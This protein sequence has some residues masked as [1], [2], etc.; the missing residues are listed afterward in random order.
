MTSLE[1]E[2]ISSYGLN[3]LIKTYIK[4]LNEL[5][6]QTSTLKKE[7]DAIKVAHATYVQTCNST[8]HTIKKLRAAED[9]LFN[10][11]KTLPQ[12]VQ[13]K[14][15]KSRFYKN[16]TE[17][18]VP[19]LNRSKGLTT[20]SYASLTNLFK[21]GSGTPRR[22]GGDPDYDKT[23]FK[24]MLNGSFVGAIVGGLIGFIYGHACGYE[25]TSSVYQDELY[26]LA[27]YI[28]N[29]EHELMGRDR[30]IRIL[31]N[32]VRDIEHAH[33]Q[34][35]KSQETNNEDM[36]ATHS[37]ELRLAED[38]LVDTVNKLP[39]P[40]QKKITSQPFYKTVVKNQKS[41]MASV[42]QLYSTTQSSPNN[43]PVGKKGTTRRRA[44]SG[45]LVRRHS[46]RK[47]TNGR[48]HRCIKVL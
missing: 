41:A 13:Q 27:T 44:G 12:H 48:L 9:T 36:K 29:L 22:G 10:K 20:K 1:K 26:T 31:Q 19:I 4:D 43:A 3:T 25:W 47:Q 34:Y 39:K 32:E 5:E 40:F 46:T 23:D 42:K 17:R 35:V 16:I 2:P 45:D 8:E 11:V 38:K 33:T 37:I 28:N 21:R 18:S 30:Y 14:V 6:A 7:I 24:S 15:T